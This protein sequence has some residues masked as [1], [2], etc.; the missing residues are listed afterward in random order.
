MLAEEKGTIRKAEIRAIQNP[1]NKAIVKL[2]VDR[3]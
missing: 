3:S 1:K 2:E